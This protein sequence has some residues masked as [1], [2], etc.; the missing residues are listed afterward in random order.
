M[1][2]DFFPMQI[3]MQIRQNLH[4]FDSKTIQ[5]SQNPLYLHALPKD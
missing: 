4:L 5:I 2:S 1:T 3:I